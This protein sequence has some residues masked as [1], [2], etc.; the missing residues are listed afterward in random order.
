MGF[1]FGVCVALLYLVFCLFVGAFGL[2]CALLGSWFV[3]FLVGV[4]LGAG[5]VWVGVWCMVFLLF[6]VLFVLLRFVWLVSWWFWWMWLGR[7]IGDL[8]C[9]WELFFRFFGWVRLVFF[10]I[11]GLSCGFLC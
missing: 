2:V 1:C 8:L 3:V 4:V 7:L 11:L 5:W 6:L 10:G 9:F